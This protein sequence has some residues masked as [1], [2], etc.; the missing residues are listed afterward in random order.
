MAVASTTVRN[1]NLSKI[2]IREVKNK[3]SRDWRDEGDPAEN[4]LG[5]K[6]TVIAIEIYKKN[7]D[8]SF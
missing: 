4:T 2:R 8:M 1:A 5:I 7:Y 3:S 6:R